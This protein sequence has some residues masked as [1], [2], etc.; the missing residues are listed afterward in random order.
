M[1]PPITTACGLSRFTA[2]ASTSPSRR[3]PSRSRPRAS[4]SPCWASATRSRTCPTPARSSRATSA[5][6]AASVSRQPVDAAPAGQALGRLDPG[7]PDLPGRAEV[8]PDHAAPGHDPEPQPG[9]GLHHEGV[10]AAGRPGRAARRGPARRR[11]W[12][13]RAARRRGPRGTAPARRRPSRPSPASPGSGPAPRRPCPAGSARSRPPGARRRRAGRPAARPPAASARRGRRRP[14]GRGSPT[15]ISRPSRSRTASW[16]RERPM[17]TASTTPASALKSRAPG[18]RPPVEASSSPTSSSPAE[19]SACTRA[20]TAVRERP[21]SVR[22]RERVSARPVRTS[23]S[24]SPAVA[25]A[26]D[27]RSAALTAAPLLRVPR[28]LDRAA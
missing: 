22:S 25:G 23:S 21:V 9:R 14:R 27:S 18:G 28:H 11:R 1:S 3:P 26:A 6:P 12:P 7:V 17:A 5:Q 10:A 15:A 24:R 8:P 19:V 20:T 2:T 16:L 13:R 4:A